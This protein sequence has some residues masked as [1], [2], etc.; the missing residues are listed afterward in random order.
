MLSQFFNMKQSHCWEANS[1]SASQ[2]I[3]RI[4][5]SRKVHYLEYRSTSLV[6]IL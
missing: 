5:R 1:F 3:P 2:D 6:L 4:L